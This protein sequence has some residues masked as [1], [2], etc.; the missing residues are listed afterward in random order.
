MAASDRDFVR[1]CIETGKKDQVEDWSPRACPLNRPGSPASAGEWLRAEL[2]FRDGPAGRGP[3]YR[4]SL[5]EL[6]AP[7]ARNPQFGNRTIQMF[8]SLRTC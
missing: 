6:L 8:A 4:V 5:R 1:L 7:W 2:H 3:P